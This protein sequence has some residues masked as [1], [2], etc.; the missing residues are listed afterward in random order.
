MRSMNIETL[1]RF[2]VDD[3]KFL[4]DYCEVLVLINGKVARTFGDAY[5]DKGLPKAEAF[6]DGYLFALGDTPVK[7]AVQKVADYE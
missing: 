5:H 3:P 2:S 4:G 7:L 1:I 6:V